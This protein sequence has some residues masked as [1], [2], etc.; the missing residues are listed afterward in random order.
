MYSSVRKAAA[1]LG[2]AD[3]SSR[4]MASTNDASNARA[5]PEN[6]RFILRDYGRFM[7]ASLHATASQFDDVCARSDRCG[8]HWERIGCR[9]FA[10]KLRPRRPRRVVPKSRVH[11]AEKRHASPDC[12][13]LAKSLHDDLAQLL[14][15][16]LIQIDTAQ[17]APA[18][19]DVR[20][21]ALR[22]VRQLVKDALHTTRGVIAGLLDA[23]PAAPPAPA[24][25][26]QC[27]RI[28]EAIGRQSRR[29]IHADCA[30]LTAEPPPAVAQV[31]LRAVRELLANAC[32]HAPG[33]RVALTL[34]AVDGGIVFTVADDGPGFDPSALHRPVRGHC[35]LRELPAALHRIGADFTLE[36]GPGL[37]VRAQIG[38][39][40]AEAR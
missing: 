4:L 2:D 39:P 34:R 15:F 23:A 24:L 40:R 20:N 17:G 28:A 11:H 33:A 19:G 37:G 5:L 9:Q 36:T 25:A 35:G 22:H 14:S 21:A 38:W 12:A 16:A 31:L 13:D 7:S 30:P 10:R 3:N 26:A 1:P 27:L 18:T 6:R 29:P 8:D 32:K